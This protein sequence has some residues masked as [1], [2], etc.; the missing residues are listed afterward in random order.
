VAE[1]GKR[2][3]YKEKK[4]QAIE[5]TPP[6]FPRTQPAVTAE[7]ELSTSANRAE[8]EHSEQPLL[9]FVSTVADYSPPPQKRQ[10]T[11]DLP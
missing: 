7:K 3:A 1:D 9:E 6:F 10:K 8:E 5:I 2:G 4:K 11:G